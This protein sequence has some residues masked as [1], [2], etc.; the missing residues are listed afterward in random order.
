MTWETYA[1]NSFTIPDETSEI[2]RIEAQ[3]GYL[4]VI[5]TATPQSEPT[6]NTWEVK[7]KKDSGDKITQTISFCSFDGDVTARLYFTPKTASGTYT[8]YID[9]FESNSFTVS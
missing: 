6:A 7:V 2:D 1:T 4:D 5:L 9:D 8:L 3:N